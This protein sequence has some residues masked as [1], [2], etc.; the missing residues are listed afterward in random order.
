[1]KIFNTL[2][3]VEID[4]LIRVLKDYTITRIGSREFYIFLEQ[5]ID[6]LLP[7]IKKNREHLETICALYENSELCTAEFLSKLQSLL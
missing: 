3:N 2:K 4:R 1:M 7:E 5:V 6:A